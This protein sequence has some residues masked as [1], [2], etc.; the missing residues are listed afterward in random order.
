MKQFHLCLALTLN[1]PLSL[2]TPSS[3]VELSKKR[4]S[5]DFSNNHGIQLS[6]DSATCANQSTYELRAFGIHIERDNDILDSHFDVSYQELLE[7]KKLFPPINPSIRENPSEL[8]GDLKRDEEDRLN[9]SKPWL[10]GA[11][12]SILGI[13]AFSV[14]QNKFGQENQRGMTQAKA[15]Q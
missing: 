8:S 3:V 12:L 10:I 5:E 4:L 13:L 14:I 9:G 11:G 1:G 6:F 2:A 15:F 7:G